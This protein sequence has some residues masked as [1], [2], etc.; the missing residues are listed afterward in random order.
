[1]VD[2]EHAAQLSRCARLRPE[3]AGHGAGLSVLVRGGPALAGGELCGFAVLSRRIGQADLSPPSAHSGWVS[4]TMGMRAMRPLS[5]AKSN[6]SPQSKLT[7]CPRL[8]AQS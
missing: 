6:S 2:D 7:S 3:V 4:E 5:G 1:M 8:S